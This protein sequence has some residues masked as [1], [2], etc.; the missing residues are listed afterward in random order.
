MFDLSI[1]IIDD[2][3][4]LKRLSVDDFERDWGTL[5]GEVDLRI[6]SY[7]W[8]ALMIPEI[9]GDPPQGHE[10]LD[11]WIESFLNV[12][13]ELVNHGKYAAFW[14]IDMMGVWYIFERQGCVV[15]IS[16]ADD[17]GIK[18]ANGL[19]DNSHAIKDC[20]LRLPIP[21]LQKRLDISAEIPVTYFCNKVVAV[22]SSFLQEM[23]QINSAFVNS[24]LYK[25]IANRLIALKQAMSS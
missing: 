17:S 13:I 22:A 4:T 21:V 1:K 5:Y 23:L 20:F 8:E 12:A 25:M 10:K 16:V 6:G 15:H 3:E 9:W 19:A 24:K 18:Y 14:Q 2:E 11:Y 7:H